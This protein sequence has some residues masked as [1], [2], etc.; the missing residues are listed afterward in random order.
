MATINGANTLECDDAL[1]NFEKGKM[2]GIIVSDPNFNT[3]KE[4]FNKNLWESFGHGP[5][6]L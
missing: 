2:P 1:G 3:S 6:F 4:S 5:L